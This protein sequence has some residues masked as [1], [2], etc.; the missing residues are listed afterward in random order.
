MFTVSYTGD[1][2]EKQQSSVVSVMKLKIFASLY[3]ILP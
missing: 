3:C 1:N 2:M